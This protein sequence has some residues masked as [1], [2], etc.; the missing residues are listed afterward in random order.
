MNHGSANKLPAFTLLEALI[1]VLLLSVVVSG[2]TSLVLLIY[3]FKTVVEDRVNI[4]EEFRLV[5]KSI[6]D[7][8]YLGDQVFVTAEGRLVIG[9]PGG[10]QIQYYLESNRVWR[11]YLAESPVSMT[12]NYSNIHHFSAVDISS[13][14]TAGTVRITLDISNFPIGSL[15]PEVR[16][17][18]TSTVS[19]KFI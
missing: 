3:R 8:M 11:K 2:I 1:Y 4:N 9:I 19:L 18:V 14:E 16:Q 13:S 12:S 7:D 6:R 5:M 17:V 10:G 15:K